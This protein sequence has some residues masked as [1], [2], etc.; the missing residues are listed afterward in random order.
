MK[1]RCLV[2]LILV[3]FVARS[4]DRLGAVDAVSGASTFYATKLLE[5]GTLLDFIQNRFF[6]RVVIFATTNPDGTP[7]SGV[8][9]LTAIADKIMIYGSDEQQ[10]IRNLKRTKIGL[11]TLYI[12]PQ[13]GEHWSKH[14]GA[15]IAVRLIDDP[16]VVRR[17]E[18]QKGVGPEAGSWYFL[19]I[20]SIRPLG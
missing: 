6:D 4:A 10:T 16:A 2:P 15:R 12:V 1:R 18:K 3:L 11:V 13:K 5:K 8:F 17:L 9:T 14:A 19:D 7:N 20:V